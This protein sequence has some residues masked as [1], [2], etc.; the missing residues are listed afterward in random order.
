MYSICILFYNEFPKF[1]EFSKQ[2]QR[3]MDVHSNENYEI[4]LIDDCSTDFKYDAISELI[5]DSNFKYIRHEKNL[6]YAFATR[7]ALEN[8][9]GDHIIILDGD[10]EYPIENISNFIRE[11]SPNVALMLPLRNSKYNNWK[12]RLASSVLTYLCRLLINYPEKDINGGVKYINA[13]FK[14]FFDIQYGL[15]LVNPELWNLANRNQL[16]VK[17]IS[18]VRVEKPNSLNSK[19]FKKPHILLFKIVKYLFSLRKFNR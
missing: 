6:G 2:A 1:L 11:Q 8:A 18:V 13:N 17:F 14:H 5:L 3:Y 19:I 12:R 4:V 10:G 9:S 15:N 7:S 16:N